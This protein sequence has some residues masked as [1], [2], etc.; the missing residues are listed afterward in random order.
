LVSNNAGK[1]DPIYKHKKDIQD[2]KID[3]ESLSGKE[4]DPYPA[5]LRYGTI[6]A[7]DKR[8]DSKIKCWLTD[9]EPESIKFTPERLR[10][11]IRLRFLR[12][13]I[14][15]IKPLSQLSSTIT[16]RLGCLEHIRDINEL[17]GIE[18]KKINGEQ[19]GYER[20]FF[21]FD[22]SFFS[23][24]SYIIDG[25]AGGIVLKISNK[26][27]FFLGFREQLVDLAIKQD[28]QKIM[29]FH[30]P[31]VS[32]EKRINCIFSPNQ[33]KRL[34]LPSMDNLDLEENKNQVK[35]RLK[36]QLHYNASGLVFG[37]LPLQE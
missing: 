3:L 37:S 2:K 30:F 25:S 12:D 15:F 34:H 14:V 18:L 36:G 24:K 7:V 32:T 19:F 5:D 29:N 22:Q 21:R 23:N 4:K 33:Y 28:F 27:L 16:T 11:L 31:I 13:W 10:L 8:Q 20:L 26:E 17:N 9:P 6:S 1:T 35:I